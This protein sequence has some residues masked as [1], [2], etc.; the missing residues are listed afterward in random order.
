MALARIKPC[1]V[2]PLQYTV[3]CIYCMGLQGP[4][5]ECVH[6]LGRACAMIP[7]LQSASRS[8]SS[9]DGGLKDKPVIQLL[10]YCVVRG[11]TGPF[12]LPV[13]STCTWIAVTCLGGAA[14]HCT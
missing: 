13:Y 11:P 7:L 2:S 9:V 10:M 4:M 8:V 14:Q 12:K 3:W 5:P 6:K 1:G